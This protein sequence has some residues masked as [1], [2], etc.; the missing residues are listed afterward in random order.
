MWPI[1]R[2]PIS[3]TRKRVVGSIRATVSGTP[4][5]L[6]RFP[7]GDTVGPVGSRSCASTSLVEVLPEEPVIASTRRPWACPA[8][9]WSRARAPSAVN[10]SGTTRL[11]PGSTGR[12]TSTAL[13]PSARA[14]TTK[15]WPSARSPRK[16]TNRA[17]GVTARE[18]ATSE[19][20][21]TLA[22]P[23]PTG[24]TPSTCAACS[25]ETGIIGLREFQG[26]PNRRTP[27]ATVDHLDV[28]VASPPSSLGSGHDLRSDRRWV[29]ISWVVVGDDHDVGGPSGG[30]T[31]RPAFVGIAIAAAAQ[32]GD[33]SAGRKGAECRLHRLRCMR[34]VDIDPGSARAEVDPLHPAGH[35]SIGQT[36]HGLVEIHASGFQH[37]HSGERIAYVELTGQ[38]QHELHLAL[39]QASGHPL[40]SVLLGLDHSERAVSCPIVTADRGQ[41]HVTTATNAVRDVMAARVVDIDDGMPRPAGGEQ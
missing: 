21:A 33:P 20:M 3:A 14:R 6:L 5:S 39:R 41:P 37:G 9:T 26:V 27:V 38:A 7:I 32:N 17:P 29:F 22:S 31:H 23:V 40:P 24:A 4:S 19:V 13:A 1:A 11:N 34:E 12:E 8:T 28:A 36:R 10:G 25:T 15:S 30:C 35:P 16:A 2:A 18:S